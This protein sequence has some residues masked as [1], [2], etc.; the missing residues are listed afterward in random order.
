MSPEVILACRAVVVTLAITLSTSMYVDRQF[1]RP[2]KEFAVRCL[3][4]FILSNIFV[5]AIAKGYAGS[6]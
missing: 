4:H 1:E 2:G 5:I 3:I 6:F